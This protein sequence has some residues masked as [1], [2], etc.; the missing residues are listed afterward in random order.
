[1]SKMEIS[2]SVN[3]PIAEVFAM[4]SDIEKEVIWESSVIAA[5]QT[6]PGQ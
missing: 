3:R 2:T 4:L 5:H 6:S 1:M